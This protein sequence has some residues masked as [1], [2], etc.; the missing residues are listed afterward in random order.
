MIRLR[1]GNLA[2]ERPG[3]LRPVS[4]MATLSGVSALERD[5]PRDHLVDDDAQE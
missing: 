4:A 1:A 3:I 5:M 2:V